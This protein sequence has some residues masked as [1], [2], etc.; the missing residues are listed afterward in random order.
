MALSDEE[1]KK[2]KKMLQEGVDFREPR[3]DAFVG[4]VFPALQAKLPEGH[5]LSASDV[6]RFLI[7]R[8]CIV[9]GPNGAAKMVIDALAWRKATLPIE[10]TPAVKAELRKAKFFS[11]GRD[12]LGNP[13]VMVRSCKFDPKERDLETAHMAAVVTL[14]EAIAKLP[15]GDGKFTVLYD[16]Q[17]FKLSKNWDFEFLKGIAQLLSANYPERLH[18]AYLYP[19]G[20]I[21]PILW[22]MVSGFFD[23]RTRSKVRLINDP[24]ELFEHIPKECIPVWHGG[25]ADEKALCDTSKYADDSPVQIS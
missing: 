3:L 15:E 1:A 18:G 5:G 25:A 23:P 8:N 13:L 16:R 12:V 22:K 10:L 14:E 20:H 24:K 9:D 7:A 21:L 19:S 4:K 6:R 2:V 11:T 17:G